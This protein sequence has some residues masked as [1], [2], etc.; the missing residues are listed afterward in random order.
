MKKQILYT[1]CLLVMLMTGCD[2][3][4]E[5]PAGEGVDPTLVNMGLSLTIDPSMELYTARSQTPLSTDTHD[6]RWIVE[7]F[8]DNISG[9]PVERRILCCD[10]ASGGKH[11]IS[12]SLALHAARYHVVAWMDYV[13][14]GSMEDKYYKVNSL[15]SICV[16]DPGEYIGSEEHKAAYI[17]RQ[18]FDLRGY[19]D[20]WNE[21]VAC[22]MTLQRPMAKIQ[23]ITT[24]TD[25][26]L[27]DLAAKRARENGTATP[28]DDI[29]DLSSLRV[30]VDYD[31][32]F[33]SSFNV[34]TDKPNDSRLG[35]SFSCHMTPLTDSEAHL[36]S[37]YIFVNGSESAV[38]VRLTIRDSE[39]NLLNEVGGLNVPIVR[40]KLTVVRDDF[41]TKKYSPGIGIDPGFDGEIDIVIP[42]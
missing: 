8:R 29:Q 19:G 6:V 16:P 4:L 13:D 10:Q 17:G 21:T 33:P 5:E 32:Y 25:K 7:V 20:R 36:A 9:T 14:D 31:C 28:S 26:F 42:D 2:T 39:G 34:Y 27:D 35:M 11:S 30:T 22:S 38:I 12:T 41:L 37:D 15:S 18:E 23:F 3:V 1:A 24:D 40:G